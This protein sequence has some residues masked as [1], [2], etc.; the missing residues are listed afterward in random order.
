MAEALLQLTDVERVAEEKTSS[1]ICIKVKTLMILKKRRKLHFIHENN[2]KKISIG[3][4]EKIVLNNLKEFCISSSAI[5]FITQYFRVKIKTEVLASPKHK[6][7]YCN[8]KNY[9]S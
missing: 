5:N 8:M 1:E 6:V 7:D 4:P 2:E 9:Y 3:L